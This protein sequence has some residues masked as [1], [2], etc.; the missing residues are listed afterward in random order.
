MPLINRVDVEIDQGSITASDAAIRVVRRAVDT[1]LRHEGYLTEP[2]AHLTVL[3]TGDDRLRRLNSKFAGDDYVT[4]VLSFGVENGDGFPSLE[5]K[6]ENLLR[7]GDIA[8]SVPQTR[9]QAAD[10]GVS[11]ERELAML[12][13]HGALHLLGY[14]HAEPNDERVMFGKTD[15]ALNE[16]FGSNT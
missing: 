14:D 16:V 7:L 15:D 3:L 6:D 13:I 12:A 2:R 11:F 9:R 1:I 10:K 5:I 8:I 4:D